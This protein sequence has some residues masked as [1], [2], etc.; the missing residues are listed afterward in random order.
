M[1]AERGD[2]CSGPAGPIPASSPLV[3]L[4]VEDERSI[5]AVVAEVVADLGYTPLVAAQGR[6]ALELARESWPALVITDLMMP[7]MDGA[8][9]IESL[10][11]EAAER[12]NHTPPILLL[13]A[14]SPRY[15]RE[16]GADAI[17]SKPFDLTQLEAAIRRLLGVR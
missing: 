7:R 2:I 6:Q 11:A 5:A 9:L 17:L 1:S 15:A 4:I 8:A 14:A 13:T 10:R 3:V 16:A 12:S